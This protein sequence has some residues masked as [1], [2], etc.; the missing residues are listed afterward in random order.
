VTTLRQR[1]A[2]P[3]DP[4]AYLA[5]RRAGGPVAHPVAHC[6][7]VL[8]ARLADGLL[9]LERLGAAVERL[10]LRLARRPAG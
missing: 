10:L 4:R 8:A 1:P 9:R 6:D 5:V 3:D 7:E 2:P